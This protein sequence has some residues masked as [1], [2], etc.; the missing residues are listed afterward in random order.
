MA[1]AAARLWLC[2]LASHLGLALAP[3]SLPT[4]VSFPFSHPVLFPA[5]GIA[6]HY[7]LTL[8]SCASFGRECLSVPYPFS[9]S[10]FRSLPKSHVYVALM[11]NHKMLS[12][13]PRPLRPP[14]CAVSIQFFGQKTQDCHQCQRHLLHALSRT[15]FWWLLS[16]FPLTFA[17]FTDRY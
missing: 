1:T 13:A 14:T 9:V 5:A 10:L 8:T 16:S 2:C 11:H 15:R 17:R 6:F 3:A 12:H 4:N 7:Q